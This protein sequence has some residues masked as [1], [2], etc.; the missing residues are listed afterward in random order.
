MDVAAGIGFLA[1]DLDC[2]VREEMSEHLIRAYLGEWG[3]FCDQKSTG[4]KNL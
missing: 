2:S 1:I 4:I 3:G